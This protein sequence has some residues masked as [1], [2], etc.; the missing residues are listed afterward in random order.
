M[1]LLYEFKKILQDYFRKECI[2]IINL[3]YAVCE[4][5]IPV[6]MGMCTSSYLK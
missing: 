5:K 3:H 6:T 2:F 1:A 4:K